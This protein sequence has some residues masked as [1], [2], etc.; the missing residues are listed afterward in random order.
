MLNHT[1]V[2]DYRRWYPDF[3]H[4]PR[5]AVPGRVTPHG[6]PALLLPRS[7]ALLQGRIP[8]THRRAPGPAAWAVRRN[9]ALNSRTWPRATSR[10]FQGGVKTGACA[11]LLGVNIDTLGHISVDV[12]ELPV[13]SLP[14]VGKIKAQQIIDEPGLG[15]CPP[16]RPAR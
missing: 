10:L 16:A 11:V 8:G 7:A 1:L 6:C 12:L 2:H 5:V 13:E 4:I 14:K 9:M 3:A 15:E